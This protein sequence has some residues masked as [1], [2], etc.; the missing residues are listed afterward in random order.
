MNA[1]KYW[2]GFNS[3]KGVGPVRLRALR[4]YF[5]NLETAWR[6]SEPDLLAA[7]LDQR[8]T[9]N[10][11]KERQTRDLDQM[12]HDLDGLGAVALTL[13]DPDYP[14]LLRELP[15]APPVLY[16][17]GY[18]ADSDRWSVAV[19]GTRR[20]SVYG[21]DMTYQLIPPLVQAGITIVS[22]LA[23]GIDAAAHKATL[24]AGGRTIAVLGCGI[25]QIYPPEHRQ[26]ASAVMEHGA[27]ITEFPPGTPPEGKNFPVRNRI[28]SGLTLG[29]LVVEAP[30]GSGALVTADFA[31]EQGR[32]VF[33]VPGN[34]TSK[35]SIGPNQLIQS[36]AKL[37]LNAQDI[38]DELNLTP[39]TI[40]T[41]TEIRE[42][43][44]GSPVEAT[45]LHCLG[46][47]PLHIDDICQIAGLPITQVSS[48]LALMELKGMVRRLDGMQFSRA[49]GG[50]SDLHRLD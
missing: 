24:D 20:A 5:G 17:K 33:C 4:Q 22:G 11:I 8:T 27:L 30:P 14:A 32:D 6:A 25:D 19:V 34:V 38:M 26:L 28:I 16:V 36:G 46:D 23:L 13:D 40:Q 9:A 7:G 49:R 41:R 35:N 29:V 3:V 18:L 31:A 12:L 48:A 1:R 39:T 44:P 47:E 37:V 2:L 15:D 45:L 21:R 42:V 43:A 50:G 10:L